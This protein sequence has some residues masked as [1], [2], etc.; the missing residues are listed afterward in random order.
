ML[1]PL[2]QLVAGLV[3]L[4]VVLAEGVWQAGVRIGADQGVGD[5]RELGDVR[6]HQL[7]P[8]R[9]VQADRERLGVLDR[10][11]EG[12]DRLARQGAA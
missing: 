3:G 4:L 2:V 5:P 1:G 9:A 12:L 7:G 6:A 11:P 10:V 8:Q